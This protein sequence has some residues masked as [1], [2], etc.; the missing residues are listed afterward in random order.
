MSLRQPEDVRLR[1]VACVPV[2]AFKYYYM[3]LYNKD[4][5]L[6]TSMFGAVVLPCI[7]SPEAFK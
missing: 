5:R 2:A 1:A 7:G 6:S 3:Q 4:A